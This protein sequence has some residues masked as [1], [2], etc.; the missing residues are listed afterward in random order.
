MNSTTEPLPDSGPAAGPTSSAPK[1]SGSAADP[2]SARRLP[3]APAPTSPARLAWQA[4]M[5]VTVVALGALAV[6]FWPHEVGGGAGRG[7]VSDPRGT[8]AG[9]DAERGDSNQGGFLLD[10]QGRAVTLG[11]RLAPV[12][13]LHFWATW[14]PPC[15]SEAP[16][17]TRLAHDFAS[18]GD[19]GIV[20]V[21]V[22]DSRD[23]VSGFMGSSA[24]MVLFDPKWDVAHR[25]GTE[26]LPE[27]YLLVGGKV[28]DKFIG[29]TDWD[30][31]GVRQRLAAH[32]PPASGAG[33]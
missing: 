29:E 9:G 31:Q 6:V 24:E 30:S 33:P 32:L 5:V 13:L 27:T 26:K 15:I 19:F 2:V 11:G 28:V 8:A 21:A 1:G 25:Y 3:A 10:G 16:S 7:G 23:R 4:R 12:T 20:M 14:C 17:L 18:H 22:A